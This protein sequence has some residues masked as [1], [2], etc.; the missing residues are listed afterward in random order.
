MFSQMCA[1]AGISVIELPAGRLTTVADGVEIYAI[2]HETNGI[3]ASMVIRNDNLSVYHGNDN[4]VSAAT[5]AGLKRAVGKVDV[6]CVPFAYI[7]WYP[8][9]LEGVDHDWRDREARRL[10]DQ[11]LDKG[12]E[13]AELLDAEVVIPFGANLVYYDDATSVMNRAVLS[14]LDFVAYA[15]DKPA[16]NPGRYRPMFAGDIVMKP[17]GGDGLE[18]ACKPR[19]QTGF[20][21]EMQD[22]LLANSNR[23][24]DLPSTALHKAAPRDLSWLEERLR[25]HAAATYDHTI[26]VEGPGARPLKIEIDLKTQSAAVVDDW[27]HAAP[28]HHFR[29]EAEPMLLWLDQRVTL[30]ASSACGASAWSASPNATTPRSWRSS[31]ARFRASA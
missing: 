10:M 15:Q 14:P 3:D 31:T 19:D 8:F 16:R 13:Q 18:I 27:R 21:A 29:V 17:R 2:L 30:E 5:L 1:D 9:L 24:T 4:Y 25:R 11:Y 22:A 26:R 12:I 28:Y 20:L 6:G 7:H 23:P